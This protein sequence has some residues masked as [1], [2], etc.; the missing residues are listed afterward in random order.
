MCSATAMSR[1]RETPDLETSSERYALRFAGPAGHYMLGVQEDGVVSLL[2]H[3]PSALGRTVLD[4]GGGHLQTV[5]PLARHGCEVTIFGSDTR[6]GERWNAGPLANQVRFEAGDLL[7]MPFGDGHF[8]AVVSIRLMAHMQDWRG[9]VREMCR[10][11]RQSVV[12]DYPTFAS[13]NALSLVAF[14]LKRAVEHHT[15]TYRTFRD[16]EVREAFAANGFAV[17]AT[18]KQFVLPMVAHR[19]LGRLGV[20]RWTERMLRAIGATQ[21]VGN[22]VLIRFDRAPG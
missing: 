4:V 15:R 1:V 16:S 13:L 21:V 19:V 7:E 17:V 10:V 14:P 18:Y 6:C 20:L 12:I 3:A 22:P 11:A 5:A 9:L 2:G 8:D